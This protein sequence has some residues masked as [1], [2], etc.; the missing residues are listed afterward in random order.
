[1]FT[2]LKLKKPQLTSP[3]IKLRAHLGMHSSRISGRLKRMGLLETIASKTQAEYKTM[4]QSGT[5][6]FRKQVNSKETEPSEIAEDRLLEELK[7][8]ESLEGPMVNN[9]EESKEM[10]PLGI[11]EESESV[12]PQV[13][14]TQLL[15]NISLKN[16]MITLIVTFSIN[17]IN[18]C[19]VFILD[20]KKLL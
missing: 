15:T 16:E 2:I 7:A 12:I 11:H 17:K 9:L 18:Y 20:S 5:Q 6:V 4:V 8:M 1:M 13:E 14:P 10:E 3:L 19:A